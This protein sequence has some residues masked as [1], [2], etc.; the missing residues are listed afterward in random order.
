MSAKKRLFIA[1][2]LPENMKNDLERKI[3]EIRSELDPSIRFIGRHNWHITLIF[4]GYQSDNDVNLINQALSEAAAAFEPLALKFEKITYGPVGRTPRMI[5][6]VADR[7][8]SKALAK[9]KNDLEP[10]PF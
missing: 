6:L 8:T 7:E 9:I 1:I 5:W 2:N 4:L 10:R 3:E